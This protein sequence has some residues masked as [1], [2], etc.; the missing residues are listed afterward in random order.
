M[1]IYIPYVHHLRPSG[2]HLYYQYH[3]QLLELLSGDDSP[4]LKSSLQLEYDYVRTSFLEIYGTPSPNESN[5][6]DLSSIHP[7]PFSDAVPLELWEEIFDLLPHQTRL[8]SRCVSQL[9]C[10]SLTRRTHA[11]LVL[12][13]PDRWP[14]YLR[15]RVTDDPLALRRFASVYELSMC[16][17]I[18]R[19]SLGYVVRGLR[20]T[21][22][23]IFPYNIF[24]HLLDNLETVAIEGTAKLDPNCL[25][26]SV[27]CPFLLPSTVKELQL[28]KV[29]FDEY[30][31]EGMIS[32]AGRLERLSIENVDGGDLVS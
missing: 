15:P 32:P 6:I 14:E 12:S 5:A 17:M 23:P 16:S 20:Y 24:L 4:Q 2:S 22:W 31:I 7:I 21:N 30:S 1:R 9:W 25:P 26:P 27:I 10:R 28:S 29:A 11:Y 13:I 19:Y 3:T 18:V 8:V